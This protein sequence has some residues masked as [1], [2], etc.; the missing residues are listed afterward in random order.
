MKFC[1]ECGAKL[2][3][4]APKFCGEC[5]HK[6]VIVGAT[7]AERPNSELSDEELLAKVNAGDAEGIKDV[8]LTRS[9]STTIGNT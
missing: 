4:D 8:G 7:P 3:G 5:G 6:I 9:S 2:V 1:P